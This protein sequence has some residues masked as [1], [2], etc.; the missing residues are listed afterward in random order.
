MG[1]ENGFLMFCRVWKS[2]LSFC[3]LSG[4]SSGRCYCHLSSSAF[5]LLLSATVSKPSLLVSPSLVSTPSL[6]CCWHLSPHVLTCLHMLLHLFST[7]SLDCRPW[8]LIYFLLLSFLQLQGSTRLQMCPVLPQL[9]NI[10]L[11][12]NSY[13]QWRVLHN[14]SL[15][16]TIANTKS[17]D[18]ALPCSRTF[19]LCV[20]GLPTFILGILPDLQPLHKVRKNRM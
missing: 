20:S 9:T 19:C 10:C 4:L 16:M 3:W 18:V 1:V 11:L 17:W 14:L 15:S 5:C 6:H 12:S 7:P 2:I 8:V 13:S